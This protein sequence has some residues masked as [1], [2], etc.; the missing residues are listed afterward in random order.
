[1]IG[2]VIFLL[3]AG[4]IRKTSLGHPISSI[5]KRMG[6]TQHI[7]KAEHER[8]YRNV[9]PGGPH[10]KVKAKLLEIQFQIVL[11]LTHG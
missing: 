6:S 5:L 3:K 1:M 7:G 2:T 10:D 9:V 4:K 8:S 11:F